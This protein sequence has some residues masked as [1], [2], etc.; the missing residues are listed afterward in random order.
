MFVVYTTPY[1]KFKQ[2]ACDNLQFNVIEI[3]T[4][5]KSFFMTSMIPLMRWQKNTENNAHQKLVSDK[6]L[7]TDNFHVFARF[8]CG[9]HG[10]LVAHKILEVILKPG[11]ACFDFLC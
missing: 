5:S 10:C 8:K 2:N 1:N 4:L 9:V 11:F 7:G 3:S 6:V